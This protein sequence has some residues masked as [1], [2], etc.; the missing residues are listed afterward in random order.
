MDGPLTVILLFLINFTLCNSLTKQ[1]K[2]EEHKNSGEDYTIQLR[3]LLCKM[4]KKLHRTNLW[5]LH[6]TSLPCSFLHADE[7][8]HPSTLATYHIVPEQ[9]ALTCSCYGMWENSMD[10]GAVHIIS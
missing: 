3:F 6:P 5:H 7:L 1:T 9:P 2:L 8:L 10:A 4:E